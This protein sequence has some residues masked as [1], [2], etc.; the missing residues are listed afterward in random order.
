[1][2]IYIFQEKYFGSITLQPKYIHLKKNILG[3]RHCASSQPSAKL[4]INKMGISSDLD[5]FYGA[6]TF[7]RVWN[8]ERVVIML[9]S[10]SSR[11]P[12]YHSSAYTVRHFQLSQWVNGFILR[13]IAQ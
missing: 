4:D 6:D 2:C 1:M 5:I 11:Q 3:L 7:R 12:V 10:S 13:T 8:M 9:C